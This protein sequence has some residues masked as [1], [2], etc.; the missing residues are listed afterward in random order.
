MQM[1]SGFVP[2][3]RPVALYTLKLNVFPGDEIKIK[4]PIVR[5]WGKTQHMKESM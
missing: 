4:P 3:E 5:G 2:S 1:H